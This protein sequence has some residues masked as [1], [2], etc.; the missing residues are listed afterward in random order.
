LAL[1]EARFRFRSAAE[2]SLLEPSLRAK[3]NADLAQ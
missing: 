2:L 1:S 3:E